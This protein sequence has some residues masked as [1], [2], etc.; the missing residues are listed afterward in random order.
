[1]LNAPQIYKIISFDL[2]FSNFA[3]GGPLCRLRFSGEESPDRKEQGS[4][5]S[6]VGGNFG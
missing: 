1:M 5:E 2:I 3:A 6:T 4:V